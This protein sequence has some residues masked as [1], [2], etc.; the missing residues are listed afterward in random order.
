MV[1]LVH[2]WQQQSGATAI[3]FATANAKPSDTIYSLNGIRHNS[4]QPGVNIVDE[5]KVV[6]L[7][8]SAKWQ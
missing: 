4:L 1:L 6:I 2:G 5:R 7:K 8:Y 3:R